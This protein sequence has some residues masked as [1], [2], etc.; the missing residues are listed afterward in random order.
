MDFQE[1]LNDYIELF[2]CTAKELA[3]ASGL[4]AVDISR[5]RTGKRTPDLSSP[6]LKKLAFGLAKLAQEHGKESITEGEIYNALTNAL[7]KESLSYAITIERFNQI[8]S[9]LDINISQMARVLNYD[10]S[11]ISRIRSKQRRPSDMHSFFH[12]VSVFIVRSYSDTASKELIANVLD[13]DI[14][15]LEDN[16]SYLYLLESWFFSDS[17]NMELSGSSANDF[18]RKLDEFNLDEYIRSIHFN[19]IKVPSVPFQFATSKNYFGLEAMKNGELDFLKSTVLSKSTESVYMCSD[20]PMEDMAQDLEFGKK[21]MFGLAVMLKKGLH[22]NIIHNIDRPFEEMMLG[23]ESWIPLYMTGQISPYYLKGEHGNVFSHFLKVS[24]TA[25]LSGEALCGYHSEGRYYLTKNKEEVAHYRKRADRLLSK[26]SPLMKIYRQEQ[27]QD[28][29]N[30]LQ[31]NA[32]THGER[33]YILS[34]LS[35]YTL[36]DE[37]LEE[38]LSHNNLTQDEQTQIRD[39]VRSSREFAEELLAHSPITEEI[40]H[41]TKEEFAKYPMTLSLSGM[42]LE[43]DVFYTWEEYQ[44]HL[45]LL[46]EYHEK[47]PLHHV[48]P[49]SS[50]AFRNIQICILR[51][52]Y[53]MV[54]KE[55][56]PAIHFLIQHPK[57]VN[58]FENMIIPV[59]EETVPY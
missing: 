19:D 10:A 16:S 49:N 13:C 55:K 1:L 41:L 5:Y 58:A 42:F 36:T 43:K 12:S 34:S 44:T 9:L 4:T 22:L 30:F 20:M 25:A 28:F 39:Y 3:D 59:T 21:W 24:G 52:K 18:L 31:Q 40:P 32:H 54:S 37:L 33:H 53:V 29:Q 35:L 6:Q 7:G 26:A 51:G 15:H 14:Q 50:P 23:L 45:H 48:K 46:Q 47:H 11:Y 27:T 8:I 57:M 17:E 56:A 38:I 2:S